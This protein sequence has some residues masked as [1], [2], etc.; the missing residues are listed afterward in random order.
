M[1]WLRDGAT[2]N[3]RKLLANGLFGSSLNR[4]C[5]SSVAFL[6]VAGTYVIIYNYKYNTLKKL[7]LF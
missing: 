3:A 1:A 4:H 7:E 5:S 6:T 2:E